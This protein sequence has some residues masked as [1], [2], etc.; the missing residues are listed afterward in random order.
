MTAE[1]RAIDCDVH[2][3]VPDVKVLLPHMEEF[4]RDSVEDRGLT[5]LDTIS[6]PSKAPLSA[7][8]EWRVRRMTE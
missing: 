5:S 2:P 4:W 3:T 6:Y 1:P 8:P 7:R